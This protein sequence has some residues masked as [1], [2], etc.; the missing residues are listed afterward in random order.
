[1]QFR[2]GM[3]NAHVRIIREFEEELRMYGYDPG[4]IMSMVQ[5][6]GRYA[7]GRLKYST[8]K[9]RLCNVLGCKRRTRVN[10]R[11]YCWL[12]ASDLEYNYA[13]KLTTEEVVNMCVEMLE[14]AKN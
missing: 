5:A 10:S 6:Y 3:D 1:M 11:C 14:N 9:H 4:I 8:S 13:K 7:P 2:G 12:H